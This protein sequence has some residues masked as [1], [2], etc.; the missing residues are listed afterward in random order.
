[1]CPNVRAAGSRSAGFTCFYFCFPLSFASL[2]NASLRKPLALL[3]CR[4]VVRSAI[5]K[6]FHQYHNLTHHSLAFFPHIIS[7]G[8]NIMVSFLNSKSRVNTDPQSFGFVAERRSCSILPLLILK[9]AKYT[10]LD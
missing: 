8:I 5:F 1:M 7:C 10:K 9:L 4:L 6:Y 2:M 3:G